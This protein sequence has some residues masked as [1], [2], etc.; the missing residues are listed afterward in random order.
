MTL[1]A[2]GEGGTFASPRLDLQLKCTERLEPSVDPIPFELKLKNYDDLRTA[3]VMVPR[4]L[5]VVAVPPSVEHWTEQTEE[6]LVLR[7]CAYWL[8]LRGQP[9]AEA[10]TK[11]T[12]YEPRSHQ[13][14]R[15]ALREIMDRAGRGELL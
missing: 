5:V 6:R 2:R 14:S 4:I 7:K 12:I 13:L 9:P 8:S 11:K 15:T 10:S 1:H 3:K